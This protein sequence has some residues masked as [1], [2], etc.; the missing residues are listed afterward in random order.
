MKLLM[1]R[2]LNHW[3]VRWLTYRYLWINDLLTCIGTITD[4][5]LVISDETSYLINS[6]TGHKNFFIGT[7]RKIPFGPTGLNQAAWKRIEEL[8]KRYANS[9]AIIH[10]YLLQ[11]KLEY[12]LHIGKVQKSFDKPYQPP[13][14]SL[15]CTNG[16]LLPNG[17]QIPMSKGWM[18]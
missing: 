5:I 2:V 14:C 8:L 15:P 13:G 17:V 3:K 11:S 10:I 4:N 16:I 1:E 7:E 12:P 18:D 6:K 9:G